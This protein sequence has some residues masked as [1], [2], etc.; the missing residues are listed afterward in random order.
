MGRQKDMN[1]L[2][3]IEQEKVNEYQRTL[4][5]QEITKEQEIAHDQTPTFS[6]SNV[7]NNE[8]PSK[9]L[10]EEKA[11]SRRILGKQ[12][13]AEDEEMKSYLQKVEERIR[14]RNEEE[15]KKLE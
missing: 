6:S 11:K 5:L 12:K 13:E 10:T 15:N 9:E 14:K 4:E 8:N 2:K 3:E 7:Q 1:R